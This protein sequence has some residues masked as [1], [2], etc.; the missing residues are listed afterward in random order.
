MS[1]TTGITVDTV[2]PAWAASYKQRKYI[3]GLLDE[4]DVSEL[5]KTNLLEVIENVDLPKTGENSASSI[6]SMLLGLKRKPK[7]A[8][9]REATPAEPSN[10][11]LL[12]TG[13]FAIPVSE[14]SP[15]LQVLAGHS[16]L[17]FGEVR[18]WQKRRFVNALKGAPG[19]FARTRLAKETAH[20][21]REVVD[22]LIRD[23]HKYVKLFGEHYTCCGSCG[24]ELSDDTSRAL[25]LGPECRKKFGL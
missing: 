4:R 11:Y 21:R 1:T 7:S 5:T 15:E 20:L 8:A 13:M 14:L 24:A 6:I 23:Q 22:I 9:P 19:A 10:L 2:L 3:R 18:E 16:D 25:K 12:Q 17:L